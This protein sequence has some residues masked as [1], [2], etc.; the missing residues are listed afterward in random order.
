M[1]NQYCRVGAVTPITSGNQAVSILEFRY[2]SFIEKAA[3][4][5]YMDTNLGEFFKK[6][7]QGIKKV[8]ENLG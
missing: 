4:A 3:D 1:K 8:L 6:K 7:A 5:T 2:Q